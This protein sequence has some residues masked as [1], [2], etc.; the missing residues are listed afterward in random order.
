MTA[1]S[2][3][4]MTASSSATMTASSSATIMAGAAAEHYYY[5]SVVSE[6]KKRGLKRVKAR[7]FRS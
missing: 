7:F 4:T 5:A 6:V 2:S 3:A 1:S